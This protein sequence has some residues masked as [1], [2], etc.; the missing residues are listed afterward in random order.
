MF[1]PQ[2]F[3]R[4]VISHAIAV[5]SIDTYPLLLAIQG[6]P[7]DGKS[8]QT[9]ESLRLGGF[10]VFPLSAAALGGSHEGDSVQ[11]VRD[12]YERARAYRTSP[13]SP[14]YPAI[15]LEDFDLSPANQRVDSRYTVNSQL[16]VGF[17]MN[18]ADDLGMCQLSTTERYPVFLTGN[19]F[20]MMHGPLM[21]P[22][23]M[24][25][26][27]WEPNADERARVI[28]HML[29]PY[30][31]G[32]SGG[33]AVKLATRYAAA[34]LAAFSAAIHDCL[35]SRAYEHARSVGELDLDA[36]RKAFR[37]PALTFE[38]F[39][40]ALKLRHDESVKPRRFI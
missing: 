2:R 32:L 27:T 9:R 12:L 33:Q 3:H 16:L 20:S 29:G 24:N 26:F 18:M 11:G 19:D 23:R 38:E 5:A 21:R 40:M 14:G 1:I 25:I 31:V 37:A 10:V 30:V 4:A 22:G 7:G 35:A 39:E 8:Y 15:L 17:L 13:Q 28:Y 6:R 36:T 34:P